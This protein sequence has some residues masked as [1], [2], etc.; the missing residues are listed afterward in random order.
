[1]RKLD[2]EFIVGLFMIAGIAC[3]TWLA[4][5]LGGL[6]VLGGGRYELRAVFAQC[7][8]LKIGSSVVIAGVDVGLVK[9]VSLHDYQ[10]SVI[11]AINHGVKIQDD[12]IASIKTRGLLGEKFV[13]ISPGAS[14]VILK[15]GQR[16][17]ETE[18]P[19]DIE[20]LISKYI[21]SAQPGGK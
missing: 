12:A 13:E 14:D 9:R 1:M 17:R 4:I 10:A 3:L 16:I 20:A 21:F 11:L 18:P 8:G 19:I 5:R 7:G 6:E 2:L 15:D